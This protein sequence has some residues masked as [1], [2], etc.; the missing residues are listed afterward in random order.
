MTRWGGT[1]RC[2]EEARHGELGVMQNGMKKKK[3]IYKASK[4]THT[5]MKGEKTKNIDHFVDYAI[6]TYIFIMGHEYAKALG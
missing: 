3:H 2:G 6:L 1:V 5:E 4:E